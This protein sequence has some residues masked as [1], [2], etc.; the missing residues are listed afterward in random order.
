MRT[1]HP[2]TPVV[3]Q[4]KIETISPVIPDVPKIEPV[5]RGDL[6]QE[7]VH[8]AILE[9]IKNQSSCRLLTAEL[10]LW[11]DLEIDS[12]HTLD[13]VMGLEDEFDIEIDDET[14]FDWFASDK[15]T[16]GGVV[17]LIKQMV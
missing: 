11:D 12:I 7:R 17:Q 3:D 10:T 8:K 15:A 6:I 4:P 5:E 1:F 14:A 16:V 2:D 13:L 9:T